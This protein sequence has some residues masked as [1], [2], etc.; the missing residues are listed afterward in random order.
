MNVELSKEDR[1]YLTA[2]LTLQQLKGPN[3]KFTERENERT[4]EGIKILIHKM[5]GE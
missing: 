5:M 2:L 3:P 1:A 4:K